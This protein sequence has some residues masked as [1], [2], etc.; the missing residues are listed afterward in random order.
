MR[1]EADMRK[2]IVTI[3]GENYSIQSDN[4]EEYVNRLVR[5]IDLRLK[6]IME[7]S[8]KL[9]PYSAAVLCALNL[10]D[11]LFLANEKEK[12]LMNMIEKI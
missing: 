3:C 1:N 5:D 9:S 2:F 4:S 8:P 11:E 10:A 7:K 6:S 12:E